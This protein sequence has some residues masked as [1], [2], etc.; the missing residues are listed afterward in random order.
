MN[1]MYM[2][3]FIKTEKMYTKDLSQNFHNLLHITT[4]TY[5]RM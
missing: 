2:Y 5:I 1:C 3:R 4:S